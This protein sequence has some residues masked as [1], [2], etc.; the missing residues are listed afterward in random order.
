MPEGNQTGDQG[1]PVA[2]LQ[3]LLA[4][5]NNDAMGVA[6][7]LF[8]ENY[9]HREQIRQLKEQLTAAQAKAPGEGAVVLTPEQAK[10]W[11]GYQTL[12]TVEVIT[13]GLKEKETAQG[14]LTTLRKAATLRDVA[15]AH[16]YDA[17]VLQT[18]GG[19]LEFE[20][21]D[22]T[23]EGQTR[24]AA[25][26]KDNGTQVRL[27]QYAQQKWGKFLPS[28]TASGAALGTQG[29]ATGNQGAAGTKFL[30]QGAG[31]STQGADVVGKF[32]QDA[33][34]ARTA[35]PNPLLPKV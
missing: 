13:Q 7:L 5:N 12:G 24:K 22:E 30:A 35:R 9:Q 31:G 15:A 28:L 18:L 23:V 27:D 6:G 33:E 17:E 4:R 8:S 32:M 10:A 3:A 25:F 2:G 34:V 29:Q 11:T 16:G 26:V 14:E 21:R 20:L 19:A 1:N